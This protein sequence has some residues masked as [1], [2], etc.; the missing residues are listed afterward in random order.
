MVR[1]GLGRVSL[2][3]QGEAGLGSAEARRR[4]ADGAKARQAADAGNLRT[5][6]AMRSAA[7]GS[8]ST[9]T[10]MWWALACRSMTPSAITPTWPFQ[11]MRSP[12]SRPSMRLG[13]RNAAAEFGCL[14]VAVARALDAGREERRL[15]EARAVDADAVA[16]APEI[17]RADEAFG[18]IDE[19]ALE[20]VE[21]R[22]V[23]AD[24][25]A[26]CR[27]LGKFSIPRTMGNPN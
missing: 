25:E 26:A 5:V 7:S 9:T 23:P 1:R 10:V 21:G 20:V 27:K 24:D 18:D 6:L 16:S 3:L 11:K 4:R 19:I 14:H 8:V 15:D 17:G 13:D 2:P 22:D 12:R